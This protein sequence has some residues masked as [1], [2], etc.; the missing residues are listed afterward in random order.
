ML[1]SSRWTDLLITLAVT[2]L[3]IGLLA[4]VFESLQ[5]KCHPACDGDDWKPVLWVPAHGR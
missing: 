4:T 3:F 1:M 2:L 5:T